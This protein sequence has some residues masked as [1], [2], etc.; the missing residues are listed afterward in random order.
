MN[1]KPIVAA[2]VSALMK[3]RKL[4]QMAI[5]RRKG[6]A[7]STVGRVLRRKPP[8]IWIPLPP[9]PKPL[10]LIRGNCWYLTSTR[11]THPPYSPSAPARR[12]FTTAYGKPLSIWQKSTRVSSHSKKI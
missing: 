1:L 8:P 11:L 5:K 3:H 9:S 10:T 12:P 2:N 6:I 7:Q 4:S